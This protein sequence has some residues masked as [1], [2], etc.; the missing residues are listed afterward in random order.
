LETTLS[1][2]GTP[3]TSYTP[4]T[5]PTNHASKNLANY[6]YIKKDIATYYKRTLFWQIIT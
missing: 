4:A 1:T 5:Q 3:T 2:T 6:N